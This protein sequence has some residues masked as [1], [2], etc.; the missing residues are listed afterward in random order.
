MPTRFYLRDLASS[1]G[2]AGQKVGSP[3]TGRTSVNAITTTTAGG[4][5]IIVTQ[6]AGG[7]ALS[8]FS[9]PITA[10]VTIS[11]TVTVNIRGL[12]AANTVNAGAGVLIERTNNAGTVQ[13]TIVADS[14]VPATITEWGTT[15]S[16][17]T[18]TYTPTSTNIAAGERIK[19]TLKVRNVGTMAANASGVTNSYDGPAAAAA[20]ETYVQ[21]NEDFVMDM[22][23]DVSPFEIVGCGYYG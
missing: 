2:G 11:G 12:E 17:R 18:G 21:F 8:W 20:G 16:A 5:N 13:S 14:T 3:R 1:L 23:Q 19:I 4:T 22:V 10:A 7:Q 9:D 6:T 15:D